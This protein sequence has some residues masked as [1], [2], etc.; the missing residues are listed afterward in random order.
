MQFGLKI[1]IFY[2]LKI[3]IKKMIF[4]SPIWDS[5]S[6]AKSC[7]WRSN[8]IFSIV[9]IE[10]STICYTL[11]NMIYL[12]FEEERKPKFFFKL[13]WKVNFYLVKILKNVIIILVLDFLWTVFFRGMLFWFSRLFIWS[14]CLVQ[15]LIS[16]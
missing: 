7:I 9:S 16:I 12:Y 2:W 6:N 1:F 5:F 4:L 10:L 11:P 14:R 13:I 8:T 15:P 3:A